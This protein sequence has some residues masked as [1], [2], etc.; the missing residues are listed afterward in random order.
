MPGFQT[1]PEASVPSKDRF[2]VFI[3]TNYENKTLSERYCCY[4]GSNN[5]FLKHKTPY[6]I[7]VYNGSDGEAN[8]II[9]I[10]SEVIGKFRVESKKSV[11]IKRSIKVARNFTFVSQYSNIACQ[12]EKQMYNDT[13]I[14]KVIIQPEG[15]SIPEKSYFV[16]QYDMTRNHHRSSVMD[17]LDKLDSFDNY[18]FSHNKINL[19]NERFDKYGNACHDMTDTGRPQGLV[20]ETDGCHNKKNYGITV[21]GDYVNQDFIPEKYPL[22]F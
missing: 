16:N 7:G 8:A 13:S 1:N 19:S 6:G 17:S 14:V 21:L 15:M 5:I 9:F 22:Q 12:N 4:D 3:S 10:G 11:I 18:D 20:V 2:G